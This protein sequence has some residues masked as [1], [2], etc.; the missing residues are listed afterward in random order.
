MYITFKKYV[1]QIN[2]VYILSNQSNMFSLSF[3]HVD[4]FQPFYNY[5]YFN[6]REGFKKINN[7]IMVTF[8]EFLV[9]HTLSNLVSDFCFVSYG[10]MIHSEYKNQ[11][12]QPL[13][14]CVPFILLIICI[15]YKISVHKKTQKSM[16]RRHS[17]LD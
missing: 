9:Y 7:A 6:I 3:L 12:Q 2:Q 10:I 11:D 8:S 17:Y 13:R 15:F 5:M 14:N 16:T 1:A 4:I